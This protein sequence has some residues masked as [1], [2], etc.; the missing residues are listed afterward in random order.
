MLKVEGIA[1]CVQ[2]NNALEVGSDELVIKVLLVNMNEKKNQKEKFFFI[3]LLLN[4]TS[5]V[6]FRFLVIL[7]FINKLSILRWIVIL[8]VIISNMV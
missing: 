4:I 6:I 3:L 2:I 8:L 7:F 1:F 5:R